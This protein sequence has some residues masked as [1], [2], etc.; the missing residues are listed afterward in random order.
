MVK[1]SYTFTEHETHLPVEALAQ[2][3]MTDID[4]GE[5]CCNQLGP[6]GTIKYLAEFCG[7]VDSESTGSQI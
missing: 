3:S 6:L 5:S 4:A 2:T 7:S 1:I